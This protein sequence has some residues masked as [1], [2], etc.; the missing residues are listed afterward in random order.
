MSLK[1]T[2]MAEQAAEEHANNDLLMLNSETDNINDD[3]DNAQ[4]DDENALV[5]ENEDPFSLAMDDLEGRVVSVIDDVKLHPGVRTDS[6]PGAP[7][8][9][10]EL[11]V[12]LR[13]VLEVA[14]HTAPSV[15]R[16]YH[17][18]LE[19]SMESVYERIIS[20][21]VLPVML[22]MAQSDTIPAKR[23]A[24]LEFFKTLWKEVHK[25]GSWLDDTVVGMNA[26]P[27]GPGVTHS[28]SSAQQQQ[29]PPQLAP[30]ARI[31]WRRRQQKRLQR[32]GEMLRYWI[33]AAVACLVAGVFTA[34]QAAAS[35]YSRG[36]IAAS[37]ALR[38]ALHH[39]SRRIKD[40]D[41]RGAA[42]LYAPVM[43]MVE[44][45]LQKL[46]V[47][48]NNTNASRS[49]NANYEAVQAA[50]IKFLEIVVLCCSR[51]AQDDSTRRRGY[52]VSLYSSVVPGCFGLIF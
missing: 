48:N 44:G 32:E 10:Q 46:V 9:H 8:L 23:G 28:S 19:S 40:A 22:E 11:A 27:Y 5:V 7:N 31:I 15:A 33:E 51:K 49:S 6:T 25:A 37:A 4:Q 39:I 1:D 13:P 16:T 42:R 41:D 34:E 45:V 29:Q 36:I 12:L 52:S 14:A 50:C 47:N 20:D 21:L 24:S 30:A 18:D 26:G 2:T 43:K 17:T 35:M 38:P 3:D